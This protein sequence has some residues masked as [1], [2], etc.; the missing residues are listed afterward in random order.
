M[1]SCGNSCARLRPARIGATAQSIERSRA[2][3]TPIER[4]IVVVGENIS[5]D[6]LFATYEPPPGE[7]VANL[8]SRGIVDRDGD[9]GPHFADAAQREASVRERYLR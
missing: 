4:R 9:P 7:T 8:L 6:N 2:T 5:F 1:N 3:A